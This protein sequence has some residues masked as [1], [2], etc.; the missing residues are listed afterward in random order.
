MVF[1]G[2]LE[3]YGASRIPV[4]LVGNSGRVFRSGWANTWSASTGLRRMI[5][6]CTWLW[7]GNT[8]GKSWDDTGR[9]QPDSAT[10]SSRTI[11]AASKAVLRR[12]PT[13]KAM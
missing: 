1:I 7:E 13:I 3:W 10:E 6:V 9:L 5:W 11:R 12:Y 4:Q 8:E 2:D